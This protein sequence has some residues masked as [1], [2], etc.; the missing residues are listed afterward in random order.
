MQPTD[1]KKKLEDL[2]ESQNDFWKQS[3]V[4]TNLFWQTK[5]GAAKEVKSTLKDHY[6]VRI[7]GHQAQCTHCSWGFQLDWGDKVKDG[8]LYNKE[9]ELVI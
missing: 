5:E 7:P 3:E 2:P 6:F 4:H 8:H 9:G 1:L